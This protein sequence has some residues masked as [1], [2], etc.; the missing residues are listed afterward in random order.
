MKIANREK[1][2]EKHHYYSNS[3]SVQF[4]LFVC[5]L[6]CSIQRWCYYLSRTNRQNALNERETIAKSDRVAGEYETGSRRAKRI[7]N[8]RNAL[9]DAK[10]QIH[11]MSKYRMNYNV[12]IA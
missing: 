8:K 9:I 12:R 4:R 11:G 1:G 3:S 5:H 2:N 6:L 10:A 7:N